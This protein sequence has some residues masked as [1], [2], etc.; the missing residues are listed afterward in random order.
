M[1]HEPGSHP[2]RYP[3][4]LELCG[5]LDAAQAE[6]MAARLAERHRAYAVTVGDHGGRHRLTLFPAAPG[7]RG[8]EPVTA[9]LLAD[10]VTLRPGI[11]GVVPVTGHQRELILA[12]AAQAP[13]RQVEQLFWNWSGPLDM[14]RF[15]T[16]WQSLADREVVLRASFD[17]TAAPRL[18]L[19]D[20]AGIEVVRHAHAAVTW[21]EL[22]KRERAR[23]FDLHRP[24]LLR[25][26]LL[27]GPP[28]A[29]AWDRPP[30]ERPPAAQRPPVRVLLTYHRALLDEHGVHLLLREFL[31][32]YVSGGTLP[33]G[34]RRPDVRDHARW[35]AGQDTHAARG[36]FPA[37]APAAGAA[38]RPGRSGPP[39]GQSGPGR[40][41][42]RLRPAQ[43]ARLRSWAALRGVGESSA[44]H[45]VW[46][47]LLYRASGA[48]GPAPVSFGV[49]MSGRD[50]PVPGA[51]GIPGLL[52]TPLPMT[53]TVDPAADLADLLHE[54]RDSALDLIAHSWWPA[55]R[56]HGAGLADTV[57]VFDRRPE[58]PR[59][60]LAELREQGVRVD[61]PQGAGGDT[62]A[63]F[64]LVAQHGPDGGL[65]LTGLYDRASLADS[66]ASA[67]LSQCVH[68][69]RCLPD[70]RD[71][72]S[73]VA[74][75]LQALN[76]SGVPRAMPRPATP[77]GLALAVLRHG[78]ARADVICLI[79]VPGV[80]AG[81]YEVLARDHPGPERIVALR[82][83]QAADVSLPVLREMLAPHRRLVLGGCGP[84]GS[85]AHEIARRGPAGPGPSV[86]VVMTGVGGPAESAR[87][88][89]RG[90]LLVRA[91]G[92]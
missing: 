49:H 56:P 23:G 6:S 77:H 73:S 16:A 80:P 55:D 52:G 36:F 27:D 41:Q 60:L 10:V 50:V 31:R 76:T 86:I 45:V 12:A 70:H 48:V 2:P 75:V 29:A 51:A 90:L 84:G 13:D 26:A 42:R 64:S 87:A 30:A 3:V 89:A 82:M 66:D 92:P 32:A 85:A 53:V 88:L 19:H 8:Q 20:R 67:T 33:G 72:H 63:P 25:V 71:A 11:E 35:L 39:T 21:G 54:V 4:V 58:L 34:E 40:L 59:A 1:V 22:V 46:A 65:L 83:T 14:M 47:L 17:W 78:Q 38:V 62:A 57:V 61:V 79:G 69:L 28:D 24:G 44:L 91:S 37:A 74:A 9:A 18:V 68:L 43:T 81:A 5:P 7:D 15:A